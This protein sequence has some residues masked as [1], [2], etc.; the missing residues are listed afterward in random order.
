MPR[1]PRQD[2]EGAWQHAM[3]RGIDRQAVFRGDDD[4][5]LFCDC[6]AEAMP[7]YGVQV[8][9]WC[10]LGN[11][12][13]LL[14]LSEEGR[15]S[16]AM[17][18]LASRFTQRFNYRHGRDGPLF[19]GRFASVAVE[20]SS[21]LAQVS[22][23]IHRNPVEA[24]LAAEAWQWPWSSARAYLGLAPAPSW[25]HTDAILDMFAPQQARQRYR[26][27]LREETDAA[28]RARYA[29]QQGVP[30]GQTRRV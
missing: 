8:H 6:L 1:S 7:R 14:L 4:R 17:R 18:F 25:L 13:H 9:A 24:G 2:Y 11:H 27:F 12:F 22:R 30:W 28:T 21:H 29:E 23:Y 20:S 10:L 16:D 15:L 19:R 26:E 3:N 5:R